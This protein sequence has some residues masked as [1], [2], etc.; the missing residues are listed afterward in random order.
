MTHSNPLQILTVTGPL[1]PTQVALAD[2]HSHVWID[3]P[4]G[5]NPK[6][7]FE[8][9][10]PRCIEAEL[11]DFRSA[12]G[13][14]LVDCRPG[15]CGR[16]VRML[17]KLAEAAELHITA[18]T[19]F[20]LSRYYP[21]GHWLWTSDENSAAAYFI[22]ELTAGMQEKDGVL[23]AVIKVGFDGKIDGQN[24]VL[25]EAAAEAAR[26]T[27]AGLLF[28]T[29]AGFNAEA[30]P[31]FFEDRGIAAERLFMC[32]LDQR[33]DVGLHRELVQASVLLGYETFN[34]PLAKPE[35]N[36]WPLLMQM[37][38]AGY[39]E[40]IAVGLDM[41][42]STRWRHYGGGPGLVFLPD[43]ILPRLHHEGLSETEVAAL[44]G[45][46]VAQFLARSVA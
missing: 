43:V 16:D 18:V 40:H 32:H 12:G 44:T 9:N 4:T 14:L 41:A 23:A 35:K 37:I 29:E 46:N 27:G 39:V 25:M 36:V 21:A 42:R 15:G 19:G 24:Q 30:L 45:Q 2:A 22:N 28:H 1:D 8:L 20:H 10:D 31:I 17:V 6:A 7:R 33:P 5:I 11:K 34:R 26:Q 3:P 13:N 38:R